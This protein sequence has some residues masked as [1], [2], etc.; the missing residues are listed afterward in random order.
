MAAIVRIMPWQPHNNICTL[1]GTLTRDDK[2]L[3]NFLEL[4]VRSDTGLWHLKTRLQS[5]HCTPVELGYQVYRIN[6]NIGCYQDKCMFSRPDQG[7][8][9]QERALQYWPRSLSEPQGNPPQSE[10]CRITLPGG[11]PLIRRKRS[12][13]PSWP[14]ENEWIGMTSYLPFK[15]EQTW[16]A[17]IPAQKLMQDITEITVLV[18]LEDGRRLCGITWMAWSYRTSRDDWG[19]TQCSFLLKEEQNE[20]KAKIVFQYQWSKQKNFKMHW[21]ITKKGRGRP[22]L[23]Q[24]ESDSVY[25]MPPMLPTQR[26]TQA[27]QTTT[28]TTKPPEA[29]AVHEPAQKQVQGSISK[30]A[31]TPTKSKTAPTPTVSKVVPTAIIDRAA[32]TPTS[33]HAQLLPQS[34]SCW[35]NCFNGRTNSGEEERP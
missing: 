17:R 34:L 30:T 29:A 15:P 14:T 4:R 1:K 16:T 8:M 13:P 5:F 10:T 31:P 9:T 25:L 22:G 27:P 2:K 28:T 11:G 35:L 12:T 6:V 20:W 21:E 7:W 33:S 23:V 18:T 19:H 26:T 3:W 32:P 24:P